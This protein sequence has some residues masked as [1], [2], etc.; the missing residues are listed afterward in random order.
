MNEYLKELYKELEPYLEGCT[1][2]HFDKAIKKLYYFRD[3]IKFS[4]EY[5]RVLNDLKHDYL[6]LNEINNKLALWYM[7]ESINEAIYLDTLEILKAE[8]IQKYID[9]I[10]DC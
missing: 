1:I 7:Y 2:E 3:F 9:D 5:E 8:E 6:T 4:D 10:S